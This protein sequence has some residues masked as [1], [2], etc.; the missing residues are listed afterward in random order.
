MTTA[1]ITG[2]NKGIGFAM[3]ENL[4]ARG[5]HILVG[6]RD[7]QRG[8]TAVHALR[9]QGVVADLVV[10]DVSDMG[11]VRQAAE[12]VRRDYSDLGLLVN[13]AGTPGYPMRA[14]GWEVDTQTLDDIWRVNFLGPFELIKQL[15]GVL[16]ANNGTILNVSIPIEP[17]ARFN[18]FAYQTT[19]APL[20]V[21][22]KSL[23]LAFATENIPIQILAVTPGGTSTDLN[24]HIQGPGVKTPEQAAAAIIGFLV[25]GQDHNGQVINFDGTVY[26]YA[27]ERIN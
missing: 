20:N 13:N 19:K 14:Y 10:I 18:T 2:A 7:E 26:S 5:H 16:A 22:T 12:V 25:D 15:K 3:A 23:G 1:F 4:G 24:G 8:Q 17:A 11:S 6:A 21:M 27:G 9:A